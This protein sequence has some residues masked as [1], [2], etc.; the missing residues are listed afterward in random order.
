[1]SIRTVSKDSLTAKNKEQPNIFTD[2]KD[3]IRVEYQTKFGKQVELLPTNTINKDILKQLWTYS[4][5]AEIYQEIITAT[6]DPT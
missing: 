2:T 3:L 4:K 1:M 5:S 6:D